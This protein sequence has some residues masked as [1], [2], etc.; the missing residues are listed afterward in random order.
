MQAP[1]Y[2]RTTK[3]ML[4]EFPYLTPERAYEIVI[5]NTN[6]VA[7]MCDRISPIS[8]EKCPPHIDGCE[9]EIRNIAYEKHIVFM[10]IHCHKLYKKD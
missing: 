6:K 7:D 2:F 8:D 4:E 3:E 10:E 9:D 5:T 1:L